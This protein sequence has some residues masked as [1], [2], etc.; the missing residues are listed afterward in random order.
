MEDWW[1]I[2]GLLSLIVVIFWNPVYEHMTN[3]DLQKKQDFHQSNP[4]K[5]DMDEKS[6]KTKK[7]T[8]SKALLIGPKVPP[9]DPDEP[10]A[11]TSEKSGSESAVYPHVYG[12]DSLKAPGQKNETIFHESSDYTG[13]QEFPKGPSEPQPFL[14]DFSK[15]LK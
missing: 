1:L 5:W 13:F 7:A 11:T 4:T 2:I 8:E 14:S 3:A 12:P 15:M 9:M 10:K 6:K